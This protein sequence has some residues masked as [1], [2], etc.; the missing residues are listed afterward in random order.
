MEPN[1]IL[2]LA[3][4]LDP[5]FKSLKSLTDDPKQSVKEEISQL[6]ELELGNPSAFLL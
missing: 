4:A 6:K 3:A 2:V 5:H 1:S